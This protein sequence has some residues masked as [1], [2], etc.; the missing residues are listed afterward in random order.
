MNKNIFYSDDVMEYVTDNEKEIKEYL[1]SIDEDITEDNIYK[2]A[3]N[4]IEDAY[5]NLLS[6]LREYKLKNSYDEILIV[7]D[8]GL[9][10]GRRKATKKIDDLV[11]ALG[12]CME[13]V[14]KLYFKNKN[15]TLN[16]QAYHHDGVNN[17]KFYKVIKNK[18]YAIKLSDLLACI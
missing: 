9:W 7:A 6:C 12:Y 16:L 3:Q 2:Q 4:E 18:K 13:D 11:I 15:S 17:F 8:L 1:K 10:Y 5:F 14:N